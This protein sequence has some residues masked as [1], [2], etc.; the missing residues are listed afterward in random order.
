[1][2]LYL[3][4]QSN[5]RHFKARYKGTRFIQDYNT[6][7]YIWQIDLR[8]QQ[9]VS[10]EA[11]H[12]VAVT[13]CPSMYSPQIYGAELSG[14]VGFRNPYGYLP[15][16]MY[17]LLPFQGARA[18]AMFVVFALFLTFYII[19]DESRLPLHTGIVCVLLVALVEFWVWFGAYLV[20]NESGLPYCCPFPPKVVAGLILQIFR[21]TLSRVLLLIVSL[22]YGIVRA[23]LLKAE[24]YAIGFMTM[25]Y[26]AASIASEVSQILFYEKKVR[27]N[28]E[29]DTV[30][31]G[32]PQFALD[33]IFLSWIYLSLT[34]TIRILTEF[35]Q[36]HK[37]R[38]YNALYIT[39]IVFVSL[40][41]AVATLAILAQK[42]YLSWPWKY[43]WV[44]DVL[45]E[46]LNFAVLVA[47][48]YI[49]LPSDNSRLL[50]YST[51]LSSSEDDEDLD[52]EQFTT[53]MEGEDGL[54]E[55]EDL[56]I[57]RNGAVTSGPAPAAMSSPQ[58]AS[59]QAEKHKR[60]V[61]MAKLRRA[62]PPSGNDAF[63][64]LSITDGL[65][66]SL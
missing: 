43:D 53:M 39:I 26:L 13:L 62:V 49:C 14:S 5:L 66:A 1:M 64:F 51:Q 3:C 63:E 65:N 30:L 12:N 44:L 34:S 57:R 45:W 52:F 40:F 11:W 59:S 33:V 7:G 16:D 27:L 37:L 21:Q 31:Y 17:G 38:L 42:G 9:P 46:T 47:V 2:T 58:T 10:I 48:A 61:E 32:V 56:D 18:V 25:A 15:G 41:A 35:R 22:G 6:T 50:S 60:I 23:R 19:Y 28:A 36:T 24:M 29:D 20:I 4:L 8:T 54:D 55:L